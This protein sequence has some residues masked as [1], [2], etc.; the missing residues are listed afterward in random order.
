MENSLPLSSV[1]PL[2][3]FS[4]A[5]RTNSPRLHRYLERSCPKAGCASDLS[6]EFE[7]YEGPSGKYYFQCPPV[8]FDL[9][10]HNQSVREQNWCVMETVKI[11]SLYHFLDLGV[12]FLHASAIVHQG[13]GFV[14]AGFSGSGKSTISDMLP[15]EKIADDQ[16]VLVKDG[17]GFSI[18][19]SVFDAKLKRP[20]YAG[21]PLGA[22]FH[23]NQ[24]KDFFATP[25]TDMESVLSFLV[26]NDLF[27]AAFEFYLNQSA[28][29][30]RLHYEIAQKLYRPQFR[31]R[32]F[33]HYLHLY[34]NLRL[35]EL[36]FPKQIAPNKLLAMIANPVAK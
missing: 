24:A 22:V 3:G 34:R 15:E 2:G 12:I 14:F 28:R 35:F 13:R 31:E 33:R 23:L 7:V 29:E 4:V 5:I 27:N 30:S 1:F 11:I 26:N 18:Y 9:L 32:Q 19:S 8:K 16:V 25:L 17:Q 20:N 6:L 36:H 21:V 10:I